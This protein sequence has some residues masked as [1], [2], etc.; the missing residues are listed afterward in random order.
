MPVI[1]IQPPLHVLGEPHQPFAVSVACWA[2]RQ[3][4]AET[5]GYCF[6]IVDVNSQRIEW[7]K[8][9]AAKGLE[10]HKKKFTDASNV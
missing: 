2:T 7:A 10:Y 4:C 8:Y 6:L 5:M 1:M 9:Q 3:D